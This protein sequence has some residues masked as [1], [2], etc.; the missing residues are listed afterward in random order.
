MKRKLEELNLLDDFLFGT[1]VSHPV[2]G[3]RFA[4]ILI[5]TML[6]RDVNILKIIPQMNYYG[7]NTDSHGARLD[8]YIEEAD[9][10]TLG[11]VDFGNIYDIEPDQTVDT[12]KRKA[13]PRRVRFY[14][15]TIDAKSLQSGADYNRLRNVIIIMILP[16][17]PFGYDRIIYT[18]KNQCLEEPSMVYED[19]ALSLFLYTKGK[20]G[21]ISQRLKELLQ[22]LEDTTWENA[23]NETLQEV[24]AMVEQIKNNREVSISY[25]KLYERE[26]MIRH[27][28]LTTGKAEDIQLLLSDLGP[29]PESIMLQINNE[30]DPAILNRWLRLAAKSASIE[31]FV[32]Q[33]S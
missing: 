23:V 16:Y 12:V 9:G 15:S 2:Y 33:M 27:E 5:T 4:N 17:D 25:M 10:N 31:A 6:G 3:K 21:T 30:T 14:R 18:V 24:Q 7:Q 11:E 26:Q 28:G 8:V 1:L 13:L 20:N 19:G 32:S 22:Y 29:I